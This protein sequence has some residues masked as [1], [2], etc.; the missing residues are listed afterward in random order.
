MAR[1]SGFIMTASETLHHHFFCS[2][3]FF[4]RQSLLFFILRKKNMSQIVVTTQIKSTLAE[5]WKKWTSPEDI[6]NWNQAS[7]DWHCPSAENDLKVGGQFTFVMASKDGAMSF[8]FQGEYTVVVNTKRFP[9]AWQM[10]AWPMYVSKTK[11]TMWKLT[12][13]LIRKM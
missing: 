5:V 2:K 13:P 10:V 12:S 3:S 4:L 1:Y 6:V 8:P 9:I 7:D 11:G